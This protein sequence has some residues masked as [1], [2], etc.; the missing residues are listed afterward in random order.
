MILTIE[1]SHA[2]WIAV[3]D[4]LCRAYGNGELDEH[5]EALITGVQQRVQHQLESMIERPP[6]TP[7][8]G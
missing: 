4:V 6:A 3:H 2:E 5:E 1:F 7:G 8:E